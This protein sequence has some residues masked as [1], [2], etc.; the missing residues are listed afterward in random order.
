[1]KIN[2]MNPKRTN[3]DDGIWTDDSFFFVLCW[4][5]L[6][7]VWT[8]DRRRVD[9]PCRLFQVACAV[10]ILRM[11]YSGEKQS[12]YVQSQINMYARL[13]VWRHFLA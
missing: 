11:I 13:L 12:I 1:M 7:V 4:M 5:E 6:D 8:M 3:D 10:M 2:M 9:V